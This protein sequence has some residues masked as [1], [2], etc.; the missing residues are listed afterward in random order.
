[1]CR[2]ARV[3]A[4]VCLTQ[5]VCVCTPLQEPPTD[6]SALIPKDRYHVVV[7]GSCECVHTIAA[8]IIMRNKKEWEVSMH[9]EWGWRGWGWGLV[10][11][12]SRATH[13]NTCKRALEQIMSNFEGVCV[14]F[15]S[16]EPLC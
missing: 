15:V 13:S 3:A 9:G 12:H 14:C 5:R 6:L 7:F 1:M 2:C 11:T 16:L 8:S 4:S 10:L